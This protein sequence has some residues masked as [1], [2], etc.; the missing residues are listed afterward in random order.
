MKDT[1]LLLSV[2][3]MNLNKNIYQWFLDQ[4]WDTIY[5]VFIF[6]FSFTIPSFYMY[7]MLFLILWQ[8]FLIPFPPFILL[9]SHSAPDPPDQTAQTTK[10]MIQ[11]CSM[12][13]SE[14][15]VFHVMFTYQTIFV[16]EPV[17][18]SAREC[19]SRNLYTY[20]WWSG[21]TF[22]RPTNE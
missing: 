6:H 16:I 3:I 10:S 2:D 21:C 11:H 9:L 18:E 22:Q 7:S 15:Y 1:K 12:T 17:H 4:K 14:N 13:R 19:W 8:K 20:V 5:F